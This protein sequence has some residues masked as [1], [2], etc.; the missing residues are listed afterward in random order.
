MSVDQ[1]PEHAAVVSWPAPASSPPGTAP[2]GVMFPPPPPA[3]GGSRRWIAVAALIGGVALLVAVVVVP[4]LV[5]GV[6]APVGAANT[7]L[8]LMRDGRTGEAYGLLCAEA[9]QTMTPGQFAAQV[10]AQ[11]EREGQLQSFDVY[12]SFVE[13]NSGTRV[14]DYRGQASKAGSFDGEARLLREDGPWR[15]CG[16]REQND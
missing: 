6:T 14:V 7:F 3:G 12:G 4:K 2:Y 9:Q 16:S 11:A 13:F 5:R 1:N 15:W 8:G 10:A